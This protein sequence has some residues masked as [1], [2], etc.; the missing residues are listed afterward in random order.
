MGS[1]PG[2][3]NTPSEQSAVLTYLF[4]VENYVD[5][6]AFR[7]AVTAVNSTVPT[8]L[9]QIAKEYKQLAHADDPKPGIYGDKIEKLQVR[10]A[11]DVS[12]L[13]VSALWVP[14]SSVFSAAHITVRPF[15]DI[16]G[17]ECITNVVDRI[18]IDFGMAAT[19]VGGSA[20]EKL[21]NTIGLMSGVSFKICNGFG[22][23]CGNLMLIP[24]DSSAGSTT[25]RFYTSATI[26][27][28]KI[29]DMVSKQSIAP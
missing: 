23:G 13:Q 9:L 27:V 19:G 4:P 2:P 5:L 14:K 7:T 29:I 21:E 20:T 6:A 17:R 12:T 10:E 16:W 28:L 22:I 8:S 18:G 15:T 25:N 1:T 11:Y 24:Q 26:D 3:N